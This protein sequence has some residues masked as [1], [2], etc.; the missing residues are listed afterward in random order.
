MNQFRLALCALVLPAVLV[1]QGA[2]YNPKL[3]SDGSLTSR[4][5][6]ALR[7]RNV[8]P[9]RGGRADAV[10]GD[11]TKPLVFY[12]GAV[13]GGVW[14]TTNAGQTWDNITDGK[15][16]ISSVGAITVAPSDPNVIYVGGGEAELREDLTYGTGVYRTTDGGATWKHLGLAGTHQ[17]AAIRV[18]PRDADRAYVAAM[19]HAFGPNSERGVYRTLDGGKSWKRV[20]FL[21]DSTGSTDISLDPTN[22]RVLFAAMYRFQR[23]PWGMDAGGGRS[24]LWK[25]TDGGDSW[26]DITRNEGMPKTPIGKIG[27]AV[28]PANPRRIYATVEAKDTSGGIFRSDDGGDS[29]DRVNGDQKFQVRPF[30]YS[31]VTADPTNENT[32]YVMNLTVWKTIDG[33]KNFTRIRMPHGDTHT[34]W[35]D[36]KDPNRLINGND[37]G[38]TVSLDGGK[39]WSSINNQPTAQFYHVMT[40]NQWPYRIY[41]AQQDN[42]TVSIAS[43]SDRGVITERDW[44]PVAGC[45]NAHLAVDPRNPNITYGGCYTGFLSRHDKRTEQYRDISVWMGNY[46]G[47]AAKDVPNRFQWTFPVLISP[48]DARTLYV[49]SQNVWR[50]MDE[51]SS[52]EKISPDLTYADTTKLGRS[53]GDVHGDMTGTEW[54]ATIYELA[55]SPTT[56][57]LLW[58]GSDDGRVHLSR[59]G[60]S[61]WDDVTPKQMVKHTRVNR[62]EPSR[63]D[64]AVAYMS[65]TR[66]QLDDFRP[67]LYRTGDYGR[68]WTRIDAGIPAG[69]YTRT[70]R[71]DVVRRGLLFAGTETGVFVSRDDGAKWET[72]Q[73]NLPRASVRD[74]R[75]HENDLVAATHGRAFWVLDDLSPLRQ[76]A[77]SVTS[78]K[79]HLF[80]PAR[81]VRFSGGRALT[82]QA[83]ENPPDGA[84]VDFWFRDSVTEKVTLQFVEKSGTV[85]RS[86]T[87]AAAGD[88]AA[89]P[90]TTAKRDTA[91]RQIGRRATG[92]TAAPDTSSMI[93]PKLPVDSL[94]YVPSDSTVSVRA[95]TN[96]FFWNLRYADAVGLKTVTNDEGTLAGPRAVPG[97]YTVRLIV[98]RDTMTRPLTIVEDPRIQVTTAD[99]QKSFDLALRVRD[100]ITEIS[101]SFNRIEELQE[102]IDNRV[103]QTK[104]QA[105]AT[106]LKAATKPVREKLERVRTEL[107]DWYNHADQATLHFPV[108]LYN[109]ML[110][111]SDQVQSADAA[112]TKQHGEMFADFGGRVDVQVAQLREIE[113]RELAALNRQLADWGVPPIYI[114][115]RKPV[116]LIP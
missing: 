27:V 7:W 49:A 58:A 75:V 18:D 102:Q 10:A 62:I 44:W 79:A 66:Y 88:S 3:Y 26:T 91:T 1:A 78:R 29:W 19:G 53:G 98:G 34:M 94:A 73:L 42:S 112:P 96:R 38:A 11:P 39:S 83:G 95:G 84:L 40:D 35:V 21:N 64:P 80:T 111:I 30:Y 101:E 104:D 81:A 46:D 37:G 51:G 113:A 25:S 77:D 59:N 105:Y 100:K 23:F 67:Y 56:K 63:Y 36:P 2:T 68:T 76:L 93:V 24:G 47:Y 74:L 5:F 99:L 85:I 109:I 72:L 54:Y 71:E 45:E 28:S 50:S 116:A 90:D 108:K 52:W 4:Q 12:F 61:T 14:K 6:K 69:S 107:V 41:G 97:E 106:A 82:S 17:I 103:G 43:R 92:A 60:G 114:K 33:G 48:H 15:T 9:F 87:T 32:L 89:K 86:F 110:T 115:A 70:I 16:D 57:G 31:K 20:L 55:E 13:N 22:P 65:A 8:G